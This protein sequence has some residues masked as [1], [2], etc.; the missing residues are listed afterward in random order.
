MTMKMWV[1]D[2]SE[3][4]LEWII[5]PEANANE[6]LTIGVAINEALNGLGYV[7]DC[8]TGEWS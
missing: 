1:D 6:W 8:V 5:V 2:V 4:V 3:P 7:Q